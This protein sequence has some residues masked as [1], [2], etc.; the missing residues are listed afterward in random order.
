[1]PEMAKV[2]KIE[3]KKSV[4]WKRKILTSLYVYVCPSMYLFVCRCMFAS[5]ACV[6]VC[7]V[8]MCVVCVWCARV[9]FFVFFTVRES[10]C[11]FA[12]MCLSLC[13]CVCVCV[14]VRKCVC[15][16]YFVLLL[17]QFFV[18]SLSPLTF[19]VPLSSLSSPTQQSFLSFLAPK[20]F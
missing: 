17:S 8:C 7:D 3:R 16:V 14:L 6:S 2:S 5:G 19:C 18:F 11:V 12:W 1:M 13:V 4:N 20:S 15:I 9:F 10:V